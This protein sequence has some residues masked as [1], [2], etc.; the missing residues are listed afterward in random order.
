[1]QPKKLPKRKLPRRTIG[2]THDLK[3]KPALV[4]K[5]LWGISASELLG[6]SVWQRIRRDALES[7]Q[8]T[9]QYCGVQPSPLY[10]DP[11]HCHEIWEY[12][13]TKRT[14]TLVG[15]KMQCQACSTATHIGRS[16]ALGFGDDA[17][18]QLRKVNNITK[19][20]ALELYT[21]AM[22]IWEKRSSKKWRLLV[23]ALLISRYPRLSKL[24]E[25]QRSE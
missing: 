4:P 22:A 16:M 6:R 8:S 18:N 11:L 1:M 17:L 24:E 20:Q 7:C 21:A 10:G 19:E 12:D 3:L 15:F 14:A 25:A 5:A 9:C 23:S 2:V 13:D